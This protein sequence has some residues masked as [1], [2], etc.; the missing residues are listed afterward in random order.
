MFLN[1]AIE[2]PVEE[3]LCELVVISYALIKFE[4]GFDHVLKASRLLRDQR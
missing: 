4:F 2:E 3:V 1:K